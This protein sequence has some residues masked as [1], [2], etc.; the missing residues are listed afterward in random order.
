VGY[1][2]SPME[3]NYQVEKYRN[4]LLAERESVSTIIK[5]SIDLKIQ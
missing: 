4:P 3:F 1:H 5:T 2:I